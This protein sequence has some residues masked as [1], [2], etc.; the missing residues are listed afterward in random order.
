MRKINLKKYKKHFINLSESVAKKSFISFMILFLLFIFIAGII[1][2]SYGYLIVKKEVDIHVK[3]IQI[4][5]KSY[6]QFLG[7]YVERKTKFNLSET[8]HYSN[9]FKP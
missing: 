1:F 7:H 8:K 2:Y 4:N 6:N 3:Q 5:D 9:P